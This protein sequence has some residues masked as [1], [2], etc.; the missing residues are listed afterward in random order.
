MLEP[1]TGS[2]SAPPAAAA[3]ATHAGATGRALEADIRSGYVSPEAARRDYGYA[4]KHP[5]Q[6]R[7]AE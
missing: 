5:D 3:G 1:A 6:P 4:P 2:P 7:A